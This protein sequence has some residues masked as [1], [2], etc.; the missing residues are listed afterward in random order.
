MISDEDIKCHK[1]TNWTFG[2]LKSWEKITLKLTLT[3][4]LSRIHDKLT[5]QLS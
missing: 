1:Q 5:R 4:Q 3:G 2:V